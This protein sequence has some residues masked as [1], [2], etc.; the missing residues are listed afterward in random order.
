MPENRVRARRHE[1]GV[2][3]KQLAALVGVSRQSLNAIEA[4]G[5]SPS[6]VIALKLSRA[7][8]T[9]V[10]ALFGDETSEELEVAL[11][12]SVRRVGTR[13]VLGS[14]RE[15]WVAHPI[16]AEP[17]GTSHYAAD[18]FVRKVLGAR[19]RVELAR[20]TGDLRETVLI[21][22]C[23]PGLSVLTDRLDAGHGPGRFRWLMQANASALRAF[24]RGFSHVV[25]VH[26]P[27]DA[28]ERVGRLV[29]RHL[30]TERGVLYAFARWEAGLAVAPGN[31]AR[32]HDVRALE[33]PK[34]RIALREEGSG[35][36]ALLAGMLRDEGLDIAALA[37]RAIAAYSHMAVAQAVLLGAADVGFT[38]RAAARAFGL[39]FVPLVEERFDLAVPDD[40]GDDARVQ[41]LL[42][43]LA[44]AS[45]RRELSELG[46]DARAAGE[47]VMEVSAH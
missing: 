47:R 37:P 17:F 18:G 44:S 20:P 36:R 7:L 42:E 32:I 24:E 1:L 34:L 30:P 41:R 39:E 31:P 8:A 25:G 4:L 23:A 43:V 15:R 40:L 26:L 13:V 12:A 9:N 27:S 6:V 16:G 29:A 2:S 22:G 14:V 10:E 5:A 35:A 19:A 21:G 3:Q 46:Y 33:R 45:F 28:Q 11:G 38:I